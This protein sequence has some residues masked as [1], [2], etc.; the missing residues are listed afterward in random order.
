M[1][2]VLLIQMQHPILP[3]VAVM[4]MQCFVKVF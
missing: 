3:Y 2:K 4:H 1:R